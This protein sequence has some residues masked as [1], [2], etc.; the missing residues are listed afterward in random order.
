MNRYTKEDLEDET[1]F[2]LLVLMV[3]GSI[4]AALWVILKVF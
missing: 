2:I 3:T 1:L 4:S